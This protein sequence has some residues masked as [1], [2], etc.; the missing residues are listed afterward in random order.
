MHYVDLRWEVEEGAPAIINRIEIVG[1]DYTTEQCIRD[2]LVILPGDVYNQQRL[3]QSWQSIG[4]L[5]FFETPLPPPDRDRVNEQGDI[6]LI[7]RVKEKRTGNVNFGASMGQGTGFGGFIG[8]DQ[9][10]LFGHVQA[11]CVAVAVRSLLQRLQHDV[12][13]SARQAVDGLGLRHAVSHDGAV[14]HRGPRTQ[15]AHGRP[16]C[17]RA[18]RCRSTSGRGSTCHM[19]L[20]R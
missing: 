12:F 16:G 5:G 20:K 8:L 6:D 13:G 19:P 18:S 7:F 4:N 3:I 2:Q 9:P 11:R 15:P 10:N 14:L 1:N 17:R